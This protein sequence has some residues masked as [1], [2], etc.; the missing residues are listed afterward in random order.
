MKIS[1]KNKISFSVSGIILLVGLIAVFVVFQ[2]SKDK[3][4]EYEKASIKEL[5]T[6]SVYKVGEIFS[7]QTKLVEKISEQEELIRY[8]SSDLIVL[9]EESILNILKKYEISDDFSAIYLLNKN[10]KALVSTDPSF[11]DNNYGFR[12]YFKEAIQGNNYIDMAIGVTSKKAG[13]YFSTPVK[14]NNN[15]IGVVVLKLDPKIVNNVIHLEANE[16]AKTPSGGGIDLMLV[17]EYG[18]VIS[19]SDENKLYKSL[20]A[21][22]LNEFEQ[23]RVNTRLADMKI[24]ALEY[25]QVLNSIGRD[26]SLD[27][28][29]PRD[30]EQ[31]IIELKKIKDTPY[32][33]VLETGVEDILKIVDKIA[34]ILS[35]LVLLAIAISLIFINFFISL[36][37]SPFSKIQKAISEIEND[38][39]N[40]KIDIKTG[41]ELELL[42]DSFEGL[43]KKLLKNKI[44]TEKKIEN[45]TKELA[46]TNRFMTG[47][48]LRMKE[49]KKE[50]RELKKE[51]D[52]KNK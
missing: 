43:S 41:D 37:M 42:A 52:N 49:L 46:K 3:F 9:Q 25:D 44:N 23:E 24:E 31:E 18:I 20:G 39:Y 8:L 27:I 32:S 50:N 19:S 38:N 34:L 36:F 40:I 7:N 45:R 48:E 51:L 6:H 33:L 14:K 21:L 16:K 10:G 35:L 17:D 30:N 26:A 11:V 5:I 28:Y 13:Y 29:D 2:F 1:L 12:E 15:I 47:R 22:N 4:L